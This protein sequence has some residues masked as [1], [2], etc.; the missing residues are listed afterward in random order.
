MVIFRAKVFCDQ[1]S[2]KSTLSSGVGT[3]V[4]ESRETVNSVHFWRSQGNHLYSGMQVASSASFCKTF[5]MTLKC[6]L[7]QAAL[8]GV[9]GSHLL[10]SSHLVLHG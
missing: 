8:Q 3:K 6:P 7:P 4:A 10:L 1:L 5:F 2:T 9:T